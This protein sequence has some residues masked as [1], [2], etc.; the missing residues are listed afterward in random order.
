MAGK[1]ARSERGMG[2]TIAITAASAATMAAGAPGSP[3]HAAISAD[4]RAGVVQ[5]YEIPPGAM[6]KALN[7]IAGQNGLQLL[8]D[9]RLT[10]RLRTQGLAGSF[11]TREAL[12]RLLT[13]TGLSYRFSRDGEDV[14]IMLAQNDR[15]RNDAGAEELPA[16]DIGAQRPASSGPGSDKPTLTPENSYVTPVVSV[17]TKTDTPVMNTP[18]NV[19]AVT[20][21]AIEDQQAIT[22]D[23]ALR[24]VSGVFVGSSAAAGGF[25]GSRS[26]G[27]FIRGFQ[28]TTIFRDGFRVAGTSQI[29][30]TADRQLANVDSIEALKGPAA[31]LYGLSQ[32]GGIINVTTRD[33]KA[34]PHYSLTQQIGSLALYRTTIG[35]TGPLTDDKSLLYRLDMSYE[36][37]GAP[38]GSF[39]DLTSSE[40][41]FVAP[42]VKWNL[43]E[44]TSFKAEAE[45]SDN[46]SN[47]AIPISPLFKGSFI[48]LPR[49]VNYGEK[50]PFHTPSV[51]AALSLSHKFDDDWSIKQR[52]AYNESDFSGKI[53]AI[54]LLLGSGANPTI[55]RLSSEFGGRQ[56]TFSTNLDIVGHFDLI[57]T[58]NTLLLGGDFYRT[59]SSFNTLAFPPY[60]TSTISLA[61]PIHPGLPGSPFASLFTT[62]VRP[63]FNR[64][65][66]AGV[67]LQDEIELPYGVH[68][69]AGA[70]YQKIQQRLGFSAVINVF[71][72]ASV[73]SNIT[74]DPLDAE[75][76][77]P[78][79]G[80]LWRPQ[81]WVSLYGNYTEGFG[82][83]SGYVFP[84]TLAPPS[85]A[86]SW[87]AGAKFEFFDG[88]L[89]A[90]VDY[91][92]LVKTNV[93]IK[94]TSPAHAVSG[95]CLAA[96]CVILAGEARSR[97]PEVDIQ[98]ELLPGW[99]VIVA[100]TN[101]D[102]RITKSS[103]ANTDSGLGSVQAGQRFPNVPR[104]LAS[105]STTYEFQDATLKGLKV[106]VSY[107]YHGSQPV[108]DSNG[109]KYGVP[110]LLA[111]WGTVDLMAGYRFDLDG[112]KTTAQVNVTNLLARTYYTAASI[113]DVPTTGF[114]LNGERNY[115]PP[116]AVR[117]LLRFE[118]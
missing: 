1:K 45:Y 95:T 75:H 83:N 93:P 37:N 77:T 90:T 74:P 53:V 31:I 19:Q 103:A 78:R 108:Y 111:S 33:A 55:T 115:G 2:M 64:Q 36:N 86:R 46:Q 26:N 62:Q 102:V 57:G 42:V 24:N 40:R 100:Y 30:V 117:G 106:G 22:L 49:N 65:D 114:S 116:F 70:R 5:S 16:I 7:K 35:A 18:V 12:D 109:G 23:E 105:L 56:T 48:T 54:P 59:S 107:T 11:S 112:V 20:R 27:I 99:N 60:G 8:Y 29:D 88:R 92:D 38:F 25:G 76:V 28:T 118:F 71:P 82:P 13:G 6:S 47:L 84:G 101:Q 66:T 67:Y 21:K 14:A 87:E 63:S 68:V 110:P 44:Q 50:S 15:Q 17:G 3:A 52:V 51:F 34:T 80:L 94:D 10:E 113:Y 97:G 4:Q 81:Q 91:Y 104:N 61:D 72:R 89:R 69:M 9:A 96:G 39:I 41:F 98:G 73:S 58:R 32:P 85:D 43:T 79:F